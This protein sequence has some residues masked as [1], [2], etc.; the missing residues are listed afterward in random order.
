MSIHWHTVFTALFGWPAAWGTG[1]NLIAWVICGALGGLLL[2]AKLQAHQVAL[3]AQAARHHKELMAQAAEH[4]QAL[5]EHVSV[6]LAAHCTDLKEHISKV[7]D[8]QV[9]GGAGANP[10]SQGFAADQPQADPAGTPAG[11]RVVPPSATAR[12]PPA[13]PA[14]RRNQPRRM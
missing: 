4:H 14:M 1:G 7:A 6:Q 13:P 5:K 2:R 10:A 12:K 8:A 3:M 9:S 11:E